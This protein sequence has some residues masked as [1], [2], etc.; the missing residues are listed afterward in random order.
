MKRKAKKKGQI[1]LPTHTLK[2]PL[3]TA[4]RKAIETRN[5]LTCPTSILPVDSDRRQYTPKTHL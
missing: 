4:K 3:A 1:A 5:T 2:S